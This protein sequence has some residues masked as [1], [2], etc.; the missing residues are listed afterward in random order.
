MNGYFLTI[1]ASFATTRERHV[2]DSRASNSSCFAK[3]SRRLSSVP[4]AVFLFVDHR[5]CEG[6]HLKDVKEYLI[7]ISGGYAFQLATTFH[8][9][10]M[11]LSVGVFNMGLSGVER[12]AI[13][14]H[15]FARRMN[16]RGERINARL[17]PRE[18]IGVFGRRH[19]SQFFHAPVLKQP[20]LRLLMGRRRVCIAKR[21]AVP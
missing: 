7:R 4:F 5:D 6:D 8:D 13:C 18:M 14:R 21:S 1:S 11:K 10:V 2:S 16:R 19:P 17:Q 20:E 9:H 15:V 3:R 12:V